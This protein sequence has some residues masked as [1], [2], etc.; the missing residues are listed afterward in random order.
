MQSFIVYT[1]KFTLTELIDENYVN[2]F[3]NIKYL[4]VP[5]FLKHVSIKEHPILGIALANM[6]GFIDASR[7]LTVDLIV[8]A[9][10]I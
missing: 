9:E 6:Q 4:Y 3:V 1:K 10:Q 8:L 7:I 5:L 2:N